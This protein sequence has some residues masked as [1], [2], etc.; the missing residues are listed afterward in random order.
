[1][2]GDSWL[3]NPATSFNVSESN[4]WSERKTRQ[5]H[6]FISQR[7]LPKSHNHAANDVKARERESVASDSPAYIKVSSSSYHSD[8]KQSLV[9]AN[10]PR[11]MKGKQEFPYKA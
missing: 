11:E 1:M 4:A 2:A 9:K 8:D 7:P 5:R 10:M 6:S 3:V